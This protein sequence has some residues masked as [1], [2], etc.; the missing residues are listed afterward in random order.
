MTLE[1][2]DLIVSPEGIAAVDFLDEAET[3]NALVPELKAQGVEAIV[4]LLHE[5]GSVPVSGNG[6]GNVDAPSTRLHHRSPARSR[7]SCRCMD[8]EIDIVITGHTNW[9]VNCVI[10]GKIVTGAA[11]QGRLVTDID[12][13][14]YRATGEFIF[15]SFSVNNRIVTQDVAKAKDMTRL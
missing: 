15:G 11:S 1:G 3:V 10:D 14:I 4:V 7:R 9:A 12:A 2:T 8:D 6:A 13:Q 5:G